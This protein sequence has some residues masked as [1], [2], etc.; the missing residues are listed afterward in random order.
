MT[1]SDKCRENALRLLESMAALLDESTITKHIDM[2]IDDALDAFE[3]PE[4]DCLNHEEFHDTVTRF[5][6]HLYEKGLP[7]R[8]RLSI[9]QA[10]DEAIAL[11]EYHYDGEHGRGYDGAFADA[12]APDGPGI[13]NVLERLVEYLKEHLRQQHISCLVQQ[14]LEA[15]DWHVR[16][17]AAE[18][19]LAQ[20]RE[21]LDDQLQNWPAEVWA[22]HIYDLLMLSLESTPIGH[23]FITT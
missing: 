13:K 18:C 15:T 16:V 23:A 2:P 17:A 8:R 7:S 4:Q 22:N 3:F 14:R 19:L 10:H 1:P 5:V 11:L 6:K 20:C 21:F 9:S 12:L